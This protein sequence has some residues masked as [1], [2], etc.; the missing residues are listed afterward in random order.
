MFRRL[1]SLAATLLCCAV[2]LPGAV[3][4]E[5]RKEFRFVNSADVRF[6][7]RC[8]ADERGIVIDEVRR[9][10]HAGPINRCA[11]SRFCRAMLAGMAA[12]NTPATAGRM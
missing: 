4:A 7:P 3:H 12:L 1:A 6:M 11:A 10:D 5:T 2:L 8:H 9:P